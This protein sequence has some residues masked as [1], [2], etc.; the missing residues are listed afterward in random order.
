MAKVSDDR[1]VYAAFMKS[2]LPKLVQFVDGNGFESVMGVII[3]YN[4][5]T[6]GIEVHECPPKTSYRF[7][8][9]TADSV[10]CPRLFLDLSENVCTFIFVAEWFLRGLCCGFRYHIG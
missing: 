5:L 6:I 2:K 10:Q 9:S 4:C 3:M 7:T 8:G 1:P